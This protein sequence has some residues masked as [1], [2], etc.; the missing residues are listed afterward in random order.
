MCDALAGPGRADAAAG[1]VDEARED[2]L[3]VREAVRKVEDAAGEDG[4][5]RCRRLR[6]TLRVARDEVRGVVSGRLCRWRRGGA[7]AHDVAIHGR[8]EDTEREEVC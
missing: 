3:A 2:E 5:A 4:G 8:E 7:S 6:E 1:L